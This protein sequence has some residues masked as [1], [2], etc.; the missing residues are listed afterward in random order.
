M[1][2]ATG[3]NVSVATLESDNLRVL[4]KSMNLQVVNRSASSRAIADTNEKMCAT[5]KAAIFTVDAPSQ[6]ASCQIGA[7]DVTALTIGGTNYLGSCTSLGLDVRNTF[8]PAEGISDEWETL[9][10]TGQSITGRATLNVPLTIARAII[11]SAFSTTLSD[12]NVSLSF[13]LNSITVTVPV[14]IGDLSW[15]VVMGAEQLLNITFGERGA[16]SAPAGTTT[17]LEKV[18][19]APGTS[20]T[21][22]LQTKASTGGVVFGGEFVPVQYS[23]GIER[24]ALISESYTY[25]STGAVTEGASS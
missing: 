7:L 16:V 21:L 24:G 4:A 23:L 8:V 6:G 2:I 3:L 18:L 5:K 19:N 12:T 13:T 20:Q 22:A 14:M 25:N 1:S 10:F 15:G 9:V 17:L 11:T